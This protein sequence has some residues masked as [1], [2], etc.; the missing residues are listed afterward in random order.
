[1]DPQ[2]VLISLLANPWAL[3]LAV[4]GVTYAALV[5]LQGWMLPPHILRFGLLSGLGNALFGIVLMGWNTP[6]VWALG[7]MLLAA[8]LLRFQGCYTAQPHPGPVFVAFNLFM[9]LYAL[10][11][12]FFPGLFDSV[13][14]LLD[15]SELALLAW[16]MLNLVGTLTVTLG[17]R[18]WRP[19]LARRAGLLVVLAWF[20]ALAIVLLARIEGVAGVPI[21]P[22][23]ILS[24]AGPVLTLPIFLPTLLSVGLWAFLVS[25][26]ARRKSI[27]TKE[28]LWS[29]QVL[30]F[31]VEAQAHQMQ[32]GSTHRM[33][34]F[35]QTVEYITESLQAAGAGLFLVDPYLD[36]LRPVVIH[37]AFPPLPGLDYAP[38]DH[39]YTARLDRFLQTEIDLNYSLLAPSIQHLKVNYF[40]SVA[41]A[42]DFDLATNL[43]DWEDLSLL[44]APLHYTG[45][46]VGILAITYLRAENKVQPRTMRRFKDTS[47]WLSRIIYTLLRFESEQDRLGLELE[48][49]R[50]GDIQSLI[51]P[52]RIPRLQSVSLA[53]LCKAARGVHSDYYDVIPLRKGEFLLAIADVAGKGLE[54]PLTLA[55]VRNLIH[56]LGQQKNMGPSRLLGLINWALASKMG[57]DR[58]TTMSIAHFDLRTK[59]LTYSSAAHQPLLVYRSSRRSFETLQTEGIPLGLEKTSKYHESFTRLEKNDIIVL[60]TDGVI[61]AVNPEGELFGLERLKGVLLANSQ[62]QAD[63]LKRGLELILDGYSG[64]TPRQDDQTILLMRVER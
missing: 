23:E 1:M 51:L 22:G 16:G 34:F 56:L 19:L 38:P 55:A 40:P 31:L 52:K 12:T 47:S 39:D 62:L 44:V 4:L 33:T 59:R 46:L 15:Y 63:K 18:G 50:A 9:I 6:L 48:S 58:V 45:K 32:L 17:L 41:Q 54:V 8:I 20:P 28:D 36:V 64:N 57:L 42:G 24:A 43:T 35:Y 14:F 11:L 2:I 25:E 61:E 7:L 60:Y 29:R 5:L 27:Q 37:S 26:T 21:F 30:N 13:S 3:S 53:G 10:I 49:Q